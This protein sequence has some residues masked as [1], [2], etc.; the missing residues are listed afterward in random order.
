MGTVLELSSVRSVLHQRKVC[1][2]TQS[3]CSSIRNLCQ[4]SSQVGSGLG[5][6]REGSPLSGYRSGRDFCR[7]HIAHSFLEFT[8]SAGTTPS[9]LV[10]AVADVQERR[11][12]VVV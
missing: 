8:I 11:S 3:R 2:L 4:R 7:R 6:P 12:T 10:R 5:R 1:W 9:E